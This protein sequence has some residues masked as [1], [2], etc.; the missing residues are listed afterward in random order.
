[1]A[2]TPH[3]TAAKRTPTSTPVLSLAPLP[4]LPAGDYVV[5]LTVTVG[6]GVSD[7]PPPPPKVMV[8]EESKLDL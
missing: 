6:A 7:P 4:A 2:T 5:V 1:M 3:N 8:E